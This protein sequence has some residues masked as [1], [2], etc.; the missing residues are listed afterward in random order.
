M[1]PAEAP[2]MPMFPHGLGQ[3]TFDSQ[4]Q[5][6]FIPPQPASGRLQQLV[7]DMSP[8]GGPM[9]NLYMPT[10]LPGQRL[11]GSRVGVT[12]Q[13][14]QQDVPLMQQQKVPYDPPGVSNIGDLSMRSV[15]YSVGS[16]LQLSDAGGISALANSFPTERRTMTVENLYPPVEQP[17]VELEANVTRDFFR[18]LESPEALKAK[19]AEAME[20]EQADELASLLSL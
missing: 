16:L 2:C 13:Q 20:V 10:I 5:P 4:A 18:L 15:P 7:P 17:E 3:Q 19:D 12:G 8:G 6:I 9:Q 1:A 14:N 11:D